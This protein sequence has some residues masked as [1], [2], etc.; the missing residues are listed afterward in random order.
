M[1]NY[2]STLFEFLAVPQK[3]QSFS[4]RDKFLILER[5]ESSLYTLNDMR[6]SCKT[7]LESLNG[8]PLEK[9]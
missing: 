1:A 6:E 7:E 8:R 9:Q 3:T 2:M 5:Q 4:F